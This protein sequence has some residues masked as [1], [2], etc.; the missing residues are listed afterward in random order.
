MNISK[1]N[2]LT[3]SRRRAAYALAVV[4]VF[5]CRAAEACPGCKQAV[6][7]D[8]AGGSFKANGVAIGYAVSI[9]MLLLTVASLITGVGYLA[10]RNCRVLAAQQQA[11]LREDE[12]YS[13]GGL[14]AGARA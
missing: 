2:T 9:G 10:Y 1:M 6:G 3:I 5:A 7:G 8:G 14:P 4:L 13:D 12:V 11:A